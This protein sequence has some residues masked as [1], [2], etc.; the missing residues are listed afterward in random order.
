MRFLLCLWLL[1]FLVGCQSQPIPRPNVLWIYVEDMNN[2]M[3]AFGDHTVPTPNIDKLAKEGV[4]FDK[5]MMPAPVC[6]AVRSAIIAG[7]MQTSIDAHH[8]RSGRAGYEPV[9]LAH[10]SVPEQF[11]QHGYETFNIG[12]DDYNFIYDRRDFYSLMPGPAPGHHGGFDG[13]EFD[14]ATKLGQ[15]GKPFFGQ[16]QLRGGKLKIKKPP[17]VVDRS[18]VTLPPYYNDQPLTRDAWAKHYENIHI[19]DLQVG[20]ILKQLQDNGLLENTAVFFFSDHGMG[21]LRH[22]QFL[23]DGGLLVPLIVNWPA[24]NDK[25]R[26][27]GQVREEIVSGL[28]IAGAS[29]GLA[30]ISVPAHMTTRDLFADDY[31]PREWVISARDRCDWTFDRIRSVRT[32]RYKYIRNYFPERPY[33]Q[34]QFRDRWKMTKE[35]RQAFSQGKF[36]SIQSLFM[37]QKKPAEELYDLQ[38]DPHEI[39]NLAALPEH[40]IQLKQLRQILSHW[41]Q[42]TDDKGQ[43]PETDKSIAEVIRYFGNN[44][45]SPECQRYRDKHQLSGNLAS[46]Q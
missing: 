26:A 21:F 43:Y 32:E 44:C 10:S 3:G 38:N 2:W 27:L 40:Q 31:R 23:Y 9:Y 20:D 8:H 5:A 7:D 18:S 37:A 25:I 45:Q 22:K 29:M 42:E 11:R 15:S 17:L 46:P 16:I 19:T 12:K 6:S 24:G 14:W 34:S 33:M 36:N 41:E 28:D 35:Y 13:A 1:L 30:G 39:D 4:R